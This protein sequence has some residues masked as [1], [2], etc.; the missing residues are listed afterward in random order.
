MAFADTTV[1]FQDM[2][3]IDSQM[4]FGLNGVGAITEKPKSDVFMFGS[5]HLVSFSGV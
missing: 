5:T 4:Q 2:T 1:D 3:T